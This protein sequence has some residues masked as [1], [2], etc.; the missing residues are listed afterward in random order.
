MLRIIKSKKFEVLGVILDSYE[1]C[2]ENLGS[3]PRMPAI[4][5][6]CLI[7]WCSILLSKDLGRPSGGCRRESGIC[8]LE[9]PAGQ[10]EQTACAGIQTALC[11]L[12]NYPVCSSLLPRDAV[13]YTVAILQMWK[14]GSDCFN[15]FPEPLKAGPPDMGTHFFVPTAHRKQQPVLD[16][17]E[18][19]R[20]R[21]SFPQVA[22]RTL[23]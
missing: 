10:K 18:T 8:A 14:L 7:C 2:P 21:S 9:Q 11:N 23:T 1:Y 20:R 4:K 5:H 3:R 17:V 13:T 22:R 16:T 19:R 12:E 6:L 15:D